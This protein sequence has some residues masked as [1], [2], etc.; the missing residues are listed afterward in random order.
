MANKFSDPTLQG[1][2]YAL[3]PVQ[4]FNKIMW[5]GGDPK[6]SV[7]L[8]TDPGQYLGEF[9][10][11]IDLPAS[12]EREAIVFPVLPWTVVKRRAGRDTY[13][14][15]STTEMLFR[16]I[17][18][19]LRFVLYARD[20]Q[21]NKI[22]ENNRDVIVSVTKHFVKGSGFSPQK[23]VFGL[24]YDNAGKFATYGLLSLDGWSSYISYDRAAREFDK[25]STADGKLV[26]YRLGTRGAKDS[27]GETIIK[28]K[29]F[30]GGSSVD[31]EP[32]DLAT[33]LL[34]DV[35]QDFEDMWT[36]AQAWATCPRWN[37]EK[38]PVIAG[39]PVVTYTDE[40][41]PEFEGD[42]NPF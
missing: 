36:K 31:I 1:E 26:V 7:L 17:S 35:T 2:S 32:L 3:L 10:S 23:E 22:K 25:I 11:M 38:T 13:F 19:R 30:N 33:P 4:S 37:A 5:R 39:A 29:M 28:A 9:R 18:A 14:R 27:T 40:V 16:P 24:V 21:G 20:G 41:V 8:P 12:A 6:L 42:A 15:Y 34:M